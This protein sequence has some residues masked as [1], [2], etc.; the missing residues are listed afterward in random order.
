MVSIR[1]RKITIRERNHT[2]LSC[3]AITWRCLETSKRLDEWYK[4]NKN[5]PNKF[6]LENKSS[7]NLQKNIQDLFKSLWKK[8]QDENKKDETLSPNNF[9]KSRK[10]ND[11]LLKEMSS[12]FEKKIQ[13]NMD[14]MLI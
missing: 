9:F 11:I 14:L 8:W 3:L 13:K 10:W 7:K 12:K 2:L 6:S 4:I 5:T 1:N